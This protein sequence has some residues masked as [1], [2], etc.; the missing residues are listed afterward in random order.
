MLGALYLGRVV[1]KRLRPVSHELDYGVASLLVDVD[2]LQQ[3][4]PAILSYNRFN[5]FSLHDKDHGPMPEAGKP[6]PAIAD[7][8]WEQMRLAGGE[9]MVSRIF[10]LSYPRMLGYAFNP[11][12][13]FYGLDAEGHVRLVIF[14]VHS[15]FGGRHCYVAGPFAPGQEAFSHATKTMRVSPF[16][17]TEGT[18]GL[19][20]TPPGENIAIGVSLADAQGPLLKAYFTG[21]RQPL[22]TATLLRVL[23]TLPFMTLKVMAAIHWEALKLW[24][25]GLKLLPP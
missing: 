12:T 17:K 16:N 23:V 18:Y 10:M 9:G 14:E 2:S 19:R 3:P 24:L 7:F 11:L 6:S 15:T 25:K 8:A 22:S 1:H 4:G 20:A 5:L 13:C 21:A